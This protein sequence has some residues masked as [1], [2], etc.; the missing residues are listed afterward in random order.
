MF[1]HL[2]YRAER[3][4]TSTFFGGMVKRACRGFC[5]YRGA[6]QFFMAYLCHNICSAL[7]QFGAVAVVAGVRR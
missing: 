7:L 3:R 4:A 2:D 6:Q 5:V 1:W